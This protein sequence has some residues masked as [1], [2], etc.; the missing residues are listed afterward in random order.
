[1][2]RHDFKPSP[3]IVDVARAAG[4]STATVSRALS[5]PALVSEKTRLLVHAAIE[6]TGY[7]VNYA[8]RNL[9]RQQ[10]GGIVVLVPNLSNPFFSE[11]LSGIAA[12]ISGA[13]PATKPME[14]WPRSAR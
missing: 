2:N 14:R 8:A 5:S 12:V 11:I 6:E 9:R 13:G 10:S 7:I 4:V 1:M 3:K